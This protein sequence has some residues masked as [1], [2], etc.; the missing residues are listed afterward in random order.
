LDD[1]AS[2]IP[3]AA[4]ATAVMELTV[5]VDV[6]KTRA[7]DLLEVVGMTDNEVTLERLC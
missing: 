4:A 1:V 6:N 3:N 5:P 7:K 2:L